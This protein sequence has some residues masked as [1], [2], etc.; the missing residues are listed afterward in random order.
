MG[1]MTP[2]LLL[3]KPRLRGYGPTVA[4]RARGQLGFHLLVPGSRL[5]S[6]CSPALVSRKQEELMISLR[7]SM[8]VY[9]LRNCFPSII[10][11][12]RSTEPHSHPTSRFLTHTILQLPDEGAVPAQKSKE[13]QNSIKS[14]VS[15]DASLQ[16]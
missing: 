4:C 3:G 16:A 12:D 15:L 7:V 13:A 2:P 6:C 8:A 14:I 9:S 1:L 10:S 5:E 11:F